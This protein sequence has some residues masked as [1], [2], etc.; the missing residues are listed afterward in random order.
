VSVVGGRERLVSDNQEHSVTTSTK[1]STRNR[2]LSMVGDMEEGHP[3]ETWMDV[4]VGGGGRGE[5]RRG[6]YESKFENAW[7]TGLLR[8]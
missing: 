5:R 8:I 1:V 2:S 6:A 4:C 3:M 7:S